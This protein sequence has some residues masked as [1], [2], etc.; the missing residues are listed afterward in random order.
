LFLCQNQLLTDKLN[1]TL[2]L[3]L[4]SLRR[5]FATDSPVPDTLDDI[6]A[7]ILPVLDVASTI[8][9]RALSIDY[10]VWNQ[11][12]L[13]AQ[14]ISY[15]RSVISWPECFEL[16]LHMDISLI[17]GETRLGR[18]P[19]GVAHSK[20]TRVRVLSWPLPLLTSLYFCL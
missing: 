11:Y 16:H 6:A 18:R 12:S 5:Y 3:E 7:L 20:I 4:S 14:K 17:L 13:L 2:L 8:D 10:A 9:E 15:Y 1:T 19:T